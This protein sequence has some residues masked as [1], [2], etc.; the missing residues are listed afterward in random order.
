[1]LAERDRQWQQKLDDMRYEYE[2][3]YLDNLEE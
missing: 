1:M 3:K 2:N